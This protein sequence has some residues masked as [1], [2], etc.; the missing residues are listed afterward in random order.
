MKTKESPDCPLCTNVLRL[1]DY[2]LSPDELVIFDSLIV[3]AISFHY[4]RFFYSQKRMELETRV[5]RTRYEA[6]IKKFEDLGIIQTYVDK[7]PSSEGQIR[8]FFVNFSNLKEPSLLAKLINENSTLFEQTCAYMNYHFNR[9]IEM[10]HPQ[11]RKE[12]KKKEEKAERAEEIR[13]MLENTLNERREMY[14]KGQLNVK[15]KHQLSPT[16]LAL[17]NQQKE[18][19]LQLDRKYGKEAIN[20]SFLAY[21]DDV[22]KNKCSPNNLFNYFLSK[23]RFFKEHS[24]FIN[25]LNDFMLLYSSLGK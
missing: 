15:P 14:N 10:E 22:L 20:Q 23:D 17:T 8:Y 11:P 6:I 2:Y 24:V 16:T 18:G 4:K 13:Q 1:H 12:K 3:K 19:L 7:M 9:A 25:Y 21:Y 5:K